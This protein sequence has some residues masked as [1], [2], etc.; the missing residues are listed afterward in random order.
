MQKTAL[1]LI[2]PVLTLFAV[3]GLVTFQALAATVVNSSNLNGWTFQV[4]NSHLPT[5]VGDGSG[6]FVSGPVTAPSGSGSARL[7]TGDEGNSRTA[8]Y[9]SDLGTLSTPLANIS[10]LDYS[11][12][13]SSTS[14]ANKFPVVLINVQTDFGT[15]VIR[16]DPEDQDQ[17]ELENTWQT[18][19][20]DSGDWTSSIFPGFSGGTISD[21][22]SY[23]VEDLDS[24]APIIVN[25]IDG[26]GGF[27]VEI[28]PGSTPEVFDGYV[29]SLTLGLL[30]SD[31]T[32]D[33]EPTAATNN[34]QQGFFNGN[35]GSQIGTTNTYTPTVVPNAGGFAWGL[36]SPAPGVPVNNFSARWTGTFNFEA[37]TYRFVGNTNNGG[38]TVRIYVG[39]ADGSNMQ[40]IV[41]RTPLVGGSTPQLPSQFLPTS[42]MLVMHGALVPMTAG[43]H[44]VTIELVH[45]TGASSPRFSFWKPA[46]CYDLTADGIVNSGD[47][48]VMGRLYG[49]FPSFVDQSNNT[50]VSLN[51]VTNSQDQGLMA[52]KYGKTCPYAN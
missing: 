40:K 18:W 2:L 26:S 31:T 34:Y 21:Y 35:F 12:Y 5:E 32:Y 20:A 41:E 19:N 52:S 25:R 6:T 49:Q 50:T 42:N 46:D 36:G 1:R 30:G 9:R 51:G 37:A 7:F 45:T 43:V 47:Q 38:D 48:G 14:D 27:R 22:V 39:D 8:L 11:T 3:F 23:V 13:A 44:T 15:D 29:D 17:A 10:N 4:T 24:N 33:F 28:G 16:F